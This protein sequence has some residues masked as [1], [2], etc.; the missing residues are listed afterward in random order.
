MS[1]VFVWYSYQ[2]NQH[3]LIE[4]IYVQGRLLSKEDISRG[5]CMVLV[6]N[7]D[8][9]KYIEINKLRCNKKFFVGVL[10]VA[11]WV[12]NLTSI[13]EN[14]GPIPALLSEFRVQSCVSCG[15]DFRCILDPVLL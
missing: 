3:E 10:V 2:I 15:I 9:K 14:A 1:K 5:Q 7:F 11:Q 12:K 6:L 4:Y 8:E 13:H